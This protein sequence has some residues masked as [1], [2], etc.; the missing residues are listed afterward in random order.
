MENEKIK[1]IV[2]EAIEEERKNRY[3]K[4]K[5][6]YKIYLRTFLVALGGVLFF[7]WGLSGVILLIT[8]FGLNNFIAGLF[9]G[10]II[11]VDMWLIAYLVKQVN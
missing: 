2:K 10:V 8:L 9:I 4:R 7:F 1:A 6:R 11:G 3:K 5:N